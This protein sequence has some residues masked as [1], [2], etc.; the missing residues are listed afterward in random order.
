MSA[1]ERRRSW[2]T[3]TVPRPA[4]AACAAGQAKGRLIVAADMP[5]SQLADDLW[6][7]DTLF[8]GEPGV[9]ASYLL[10]GPHG[11][12]LVDVGSG[13]TV[14]NLLTAVRASGHEPA[15]IEHLL[16]T[17]VHLD[18]AGAAGALVRRLPQARVYVHRIGAPHL[19]NPEK[20]VSSAQRI[21]GQRMR[22]LWGAIEPV[23]AERLVVLEDGDDVRVGA[24]RLRALYTPGHAVHHVA[25]HDEEARV[26]FAGDVAGVRLQGNDFVRPPTPPPDLDLEAWTASLDRLATLDARALYLPHFGPA[27]D[28]AR[29][30]ADLRSR[31]FEWGDLMLA[32][33]RAGRSDVELAGILAEHAD[34]AVLASTGGED[35][36]TLER[37]ELASNYLM[38]A[39]GYQRYYRK[40]HPELLASA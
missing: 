25:L 3:M 8:Q 35:G 19:L 24:R 2:A 16:I 28:V 29:H 14:E 23:P 15:A 17:H 6:L 11:L 4:R 13:A 40:H 9:I 39:Q 36:E 20:L 1:C 5:A 33:M 30:L 21:Y 37:Y 34:G 26:I 38:S 22:E 31:L 18:H 10:A 7:L 32:G 27:G 12:A